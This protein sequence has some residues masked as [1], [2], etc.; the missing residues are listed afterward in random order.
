MGDTA[1]YFK[2]DDYEDFKKQMKWLWENYKSKEIQ[3]KVERAY[4]LVDTKFLPEHMALR[5][6]NRLTKVL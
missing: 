1:T 6:H 4:K 5:I 3:D 2:V